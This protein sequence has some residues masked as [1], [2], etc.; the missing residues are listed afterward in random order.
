[1]FFIKSVRDAVPAKPLY[2]REDA[3]DTFVEF[4]SALKDRLLEIKT[5]ADIDK[6]NLEWFAE[7][8]YLIESR[9]SVSFTEKGDV[10]LNNKVLKAV[11]MSSAK[12]RDTAIAK[13]FLYTEAEKVKA[14]MEVIDTNSPNVSFNGSYDGRLRIDVREGYSL[15]FYYLPKEMPENVFREDIKKNPFFVAVQ[16]KVMFTAATREEAEQKMDKL[17]SA[18]GK[19]KEAEKAKVE[20]QKK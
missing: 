15:N 5:P 17:A 10:C 13:D 9:Y 12:S 2:S 20:E 4:V 18:Y 3:Q 6:F 1:M 16:N 8:G 19:N 7:N 14:M 11:Q